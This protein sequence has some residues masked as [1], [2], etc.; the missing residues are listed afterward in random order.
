MLFRLWVI[1][2]QQEEEQK[3]IEKRAVLWGALPSV[4]G[5]GFVFGVFGVR[6]SL[7]SGEGEGPVPANQ[8]K[9]VI[10]FLSCLLSL[11][12]DKTSLEWHYNDRSF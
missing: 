2:E 7:H 9:I 12:L 11:S 6:A 5:F 4:L 1:Q 3:L 10:I 8:K